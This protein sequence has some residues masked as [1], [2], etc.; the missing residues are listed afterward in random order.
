MACGLFFAGI[1]F[2]LSAYVETQ[3]NQ[4]FISILWLIPQYFMVA[5]SEVF[6]WVANINF[7]YTQAP[8]SMKSV[9]TS[10][11][12]LSIAGG[13]AIVIFISGTKIF[14]SQV[15]EFLFFAGLIFVDTIIFIVLAVRY[16]YV[17]KSE[18]DL[19]KSESAWI[20]N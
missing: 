1:T 7:A 16:K 2:L 14:E 3:I 10:M 5:F 19:K 18:N 20:N 13:S 9:V 4:H 6:L 8:K 17:T 15:Y 12:Y 11:V